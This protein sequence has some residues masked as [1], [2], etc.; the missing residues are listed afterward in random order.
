M[1]GGN[2]DKVW[3]C[4]KRS[5]GKFT[6]CKWARAEELLWMIFWK[7]HDLFSSLASV[8]TIISFANVKL[9]FLTLSTAGFILECSLAFASPVRY[10]D[11]P[12][13]RFLDTR[14]E[15]FWST[16]P[17]SFSVFLFHS[18]P[19]GFSVL[20]KRDCMVLSCSWISCLQEWERE[21][22]FALACA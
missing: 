15:Y 11:S 12:Q 8:L 7:D 18:H 22:R 1:R 13:N 2:G 4:D 3:K 17:K 21:V 5:T 20:I 19:P 9:F 6:S 14:L 16:G 10:C